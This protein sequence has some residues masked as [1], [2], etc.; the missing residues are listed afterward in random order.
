[1]GFQQEK[2]NLDISLQNKNGDAAKYIME[3]DG[4]REKR[5]ENEHARSALKEENCGLQSIQIDVQRS[6]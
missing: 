4:E 2:R 3:A 5:T 6:K 1:M